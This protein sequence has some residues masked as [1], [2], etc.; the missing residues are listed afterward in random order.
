MS[1]IERVLK[2]DKLA[3]PPFAPP[4][5][6]AGPLVIAQTSLILQ[7]L[8]QRHG[9]APKG[10][11]ESFAVQQIQLTIADM[12]VEAHD[13]HH[14]RSARRSTT[15]IKRTSRVS[16]AEIF[17]GQRLTKFLPY[18]ESILARNS[19]GKGE[20]LVGS[21]VTYA[22]LLDVPARRRFA[23]RLPTRDE[24]PSAEDPE[25]LGS[26]P[27]AWPHVP[28]RELPRFQ[29]TN[30][31]QPVRSLQALPGARSRTFGIPEFHALRSRFFRP[32]V[33]RSERLLLRPWD[34]NDADAVYAY[35][36][37]P[38]VARY[39]SWH[40]HESVAD[41]HFFLNEIVA[42]GY[43]KGWYSYALCSPSTFPRSRSAG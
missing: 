26:S 39:M 23:L 4:F 17:I 2:D 32:P 40:R 21:D 43:E 1:A 15:K 37:D 38:E 16:R 33:I 9:L 20:Y 3:V 27:I 8:G 10:E 19:A 22:D 13:V 34:P 25:A 30:A 36:S 31:L 35:A 18:F 5:L 14:T 7:F 12:V 24:A 41:A 11:A 28:H 6:K 42:E 29:A